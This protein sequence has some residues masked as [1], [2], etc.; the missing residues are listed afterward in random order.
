MDNFSEG[1]FSNPQDAGFQTILFNGNV[2]DKSAL[3]LIKHVQE[4][5]RESKKGVWVGIKSDGGAPGAARFVY[6]YLSSIEFPAISHAIDVFSEGTNLA[7][8]FPH[9]SIA[10]TGKIGFHQAALN[11]PGGSF[12]EGILSDLLQQVMGHNRAML[13][14]LMLSTGLPEE[15]IRPWIYNGAVFVGEEAVKPFHPRPLEHKILDVT[16]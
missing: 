2:N 9:R 5:I 11:L 16:E 8:A 15:T 10:L 1:A 6:D 13:D 7:A 3:L 12:H 4:A 14:H